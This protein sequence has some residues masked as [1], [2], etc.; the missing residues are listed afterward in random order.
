MNL[1]INWSKTKIQKE[2]VNLSEIVES[3]A[4]NLEAVAFENGKNERYYPINNPKTQAL[5]EKYLDEV[6]KLKNVYFLGRL[7]DY[8]YYNMD[9]TLRRALNFFETEVKNELF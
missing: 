4:L 5:Y 7:G 8:K 2:K 3:V 1:F 9:E 6:K